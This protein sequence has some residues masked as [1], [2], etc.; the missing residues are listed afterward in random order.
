MLFLFKD[1]A[2]DNERREL[3]SRGKLVAVEP[4]VF[5]LLFYLIQNRDRV[6]SKDDMI[7]SVWGGR[8]VSDS[9]LDSRINAVRKAIGDSGEQQEFI[10]TIARKGIRFVGAV[11]QKQEPPDAEPARP[12]IAHK[13]EISFCR[14]D[15]KINIAYAAVGSGP[16]LLKTANWLTHLEYDWESPVW[17]PLLQQL[18]QKNRLIRYDSRGNGLSDRTVDDISFAS[19]ARDFDAVVG[20]SKAERFAVLGISQGAAIAIDYAVRHPDRVTKLVLHGGY[21]IG[22]NRRGS[23]EE[24]DKAHVFLSMM[25]QGWGDEHSAFMR[26]FVSV[27]IPNGSPEQIKWLADLQRITTTAENAIRIRN[28][29][30]DIDVAGL[31]PRVSVPT[32]VLHSRH[33]NVVPL[34]QGRLLATSIPNARFVTL[35]S[36]NHVLLPGEPAWSKFMSEIEAFLAG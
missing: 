6:I 14:S 2:L 7:A 5:D 11:Q 26:A 10:R 22:R 16:V 24:T 29:C 34:E 36:D 20:A 21:A 15:E 33:D 13:Q 8:V 25:R 30:D 28:A 12:A 31:L 18:A 3:R 17:L 4:Q 9:T 35:D 32:L 27:F 1:F 19:F 23:A